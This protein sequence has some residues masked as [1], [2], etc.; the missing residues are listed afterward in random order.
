MIGVVKTSQKAL[1]STGTKTMSAR[2][3]MSIVD[4]GRANVDASAILMVALKAATT[5]CGGLSVGG[6]FDNMTDSAPAAWIGARNANPP[7]RG[8]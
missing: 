2:L 7:G 1:R 5:T 6:M 3:A 4:V 8:S